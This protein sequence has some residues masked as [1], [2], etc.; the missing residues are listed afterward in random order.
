MTWFKESLDVYRTES[1]NQIFNLTYGNG[2]SLKDLASIIKG[3]F[4]NIE[5]EHQE[6]DSLVPERGALDIS[7]AKNLLDYQPIFDLEKGMV[8]YIN[9]YKSLAKKFNLV[10]NTSLPQVNE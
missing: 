1:V 5:I 4:P 9:W 7:K 2:R 8:K 10:Q 6:R 3:N